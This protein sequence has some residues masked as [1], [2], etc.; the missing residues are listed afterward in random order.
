MLT[1]SANSVGCGYALNAASLP[2]AYRCMYPGTMINS[3][4]SV[5]ATLEDI[6]CDV[7]VQQI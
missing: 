3:Y 6:L 7:S 5:S 2:E 1:W 4:Y